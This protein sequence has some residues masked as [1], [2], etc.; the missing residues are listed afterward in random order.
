MYNGYFGFL[1]SPFSVTPDPR[2]FYTNPVYLEAYATLRYGIEAKKGFIVITGEVGTGKTTLLRKLLRSLEDT[3]HSVFVFNTCISFPELLQVTLHDLGLTPKDASKVTM[4]QELND[5][6]IKRLK[7]GHTVVALI[8]EA[9]NLS[10]EVLEDLRLLSNLETDRE[11]LLQIVLV[12]QPELEAKLDQPGLRQLKQR[13]A[14][15]CRLD[16]L[17]DEEVGPYIDFRL[18]AAGYEGKGLFHREAV[19]QIALYSKGIPRLMNIIC[20]NALLTAYA[21]S[22]KIVSA[23]MIKEVARD[24]RLSSELQVTKAEP[25]PTV[26]GPK[27][28]RQAPIREI[29][30]QVPERKLR[31]LVSA[32]V[33]TLL[34]IL[35]FVAVA[36]IIDPQNLLNK[37]GK[38][39][40]VV[41]HNLNQES[42]PKKANAEVAFKRKDQRITIQYGATISK[43]AIDAYSANTVL[44][45]DLIKEF[46]PQIEDLNWVSAGQELL[47]PPLTR[48]TLL[49]QQPDGSY[50]LIVGSF[51]SLKGADEHARL[52]RSKGYQVTITPRRVSDNLLLHRVKIDGLKNL[53]EA[54][55]IWRTGLNNQWLAFAGNPAV[56]R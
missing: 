4:L 38:S 48:E 25:A 1:E 13:V 46:N 47:L 45:M 49:R 7:Q 11:K 51:R 26:S 43:I 20:D 40:E 55:Q 44:G 30:D 15:Q 54:N 8:D 31:R 32:G 42:L 56:T 39:F 33:G 50:H 28:E 18:R 6:L 35:V 36:S 14:V 16:P 34:G 12:G 5:Y 24:L 19:Q 2:F 23:D 37:A 9:Q 3:V 21:E 27:T 22:K 52:L 29:P 53:E 17:K 41:K 10:A